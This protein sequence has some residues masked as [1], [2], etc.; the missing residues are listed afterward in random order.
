MPKIYVGVDVSKDK[1]D[2][3]VMSGPDE[4]VMKPKM[5]LQN[6]DGFIRFT[7]DIDRARG[8]RVQSQFL[9]NFSRRLVVIIHGTPSP[10]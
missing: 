2:A 1:F 8:N 4:Y 7:H 5:Y 3:C 9:G 6:L 10:G